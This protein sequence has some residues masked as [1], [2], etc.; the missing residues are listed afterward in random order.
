MPGTRTSV[1]LRFDEHPYGH[2]DQF[3]SP[4]FLKEK[5]IFRKIGQKSLDFN[6]YRCQEDSFAFS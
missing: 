1:E 5:N 6:R 4:I 3:M 2:A